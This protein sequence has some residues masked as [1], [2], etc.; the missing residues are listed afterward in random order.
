MAAVELRGVSIEYKGRSL[1]RAMPRVAGLSVEF[2]IH[3][4]TSGILIGDKVNHNFSLAQYGDVILVSKLLTTDLEALPKVIADP[5]F[6]DS[7]DWDY[8]LV[9]YLNRSSGDILNLIHRASGSYH[10]GEMFI[11]SGFAVGFLDKRSVIIRN[12]SGNELILLPTDFED[13]ESLVLY[14]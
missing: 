14:P 11:P 13:G 6:A 3:P 2:T 7:A 10:Q 8:V 4:Y 5:A 1:P 12:L 9:Q